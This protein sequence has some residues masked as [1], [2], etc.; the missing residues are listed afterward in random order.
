MHELFRTA[1]H[2]FS[3]TS[4]TSSHLLWGWHVTALFMATLML[5]NEQLYHR[6]G[7]KDVSL[8][9]FTRDV[10]SLPL[11][12]SDGRHGF[13]WAALLYLG[14]FGNEPMKKLEREFQSLGV[15]NPSGREEKAF[16]REIGCFSD[17]YGHWGDT[18]GGVFGEVYEVIEGLKTFAQE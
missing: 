3:A 13:W 4:K 12:T 10:G 5:K 18:Q 8:E 17:A 15:W 2:A 7:R 11:W 6:M 14:A 1:A 9:D 16:E